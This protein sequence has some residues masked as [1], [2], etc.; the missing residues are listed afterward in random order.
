M[1]D[2]KHQSVLLKESVDALQIR[3]DGIYV[4]CTM[5]GGGHSEAICRQLGPSGVLVGIDQDDY[6]QAKAQV[7]LS[8]F[9]CRKYFVRDNF[10]NIRPIWIR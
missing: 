7:R 4:D 10:K 5:G 1:D 9:A 3:P 2:F 8:S 6:A